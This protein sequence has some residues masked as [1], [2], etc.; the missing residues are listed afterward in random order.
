[1][2]IDKYPHKDAALLEK[3]FA[4]FGAAAIKREIQLPWNVRVWDDPG[5]VFCDVQ[6][7]ET[8]LEIKSFNDKTPDPPAMFHPPYRAELTG[9]EDRKLHQERIDYEEGWTQIP[10]SDGP[11]PPKRTPPIQ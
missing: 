5:D 8:E 9:R 6:L 7:K 4:H 1:M 11:L 3:I 10:P 2:G